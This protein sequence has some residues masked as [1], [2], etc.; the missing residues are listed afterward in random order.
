MSKGIQ[1]CEWD[2]TE[3]QQDVMCGWI[4][5]EEA[6]KGGPLGVVLQHCGSTEDFKQ[7]RDTGGCFGNMILAYLKRMIRDGR[8]WKH[9]GPLKDSNNCQ[10]RHNEGQ[11]V[12]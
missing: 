5:G 8:K 2:R 1:P 11:W 6:G 10:V 4:P 7:G 12:E 9:K 3:G